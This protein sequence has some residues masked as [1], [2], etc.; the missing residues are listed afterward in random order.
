MNLEHFF[1]NRNQSLNCAILHGGLSGGRD[2]VDKIC[3]LKFKTNGKNKKM[4]AVPL[5]LS[6][7]LNENN[8]GIIMSYM[9]L[10]VYKLYI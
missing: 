7:S 8:L 4:F 1:C 3:K 10:S 9:F 5:V 6:I 2:L